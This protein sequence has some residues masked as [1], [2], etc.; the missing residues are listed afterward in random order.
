MPTGIQIRLLDV[1]A[2]KR[3][4]WPTGQSRQPVA[5]DA[6]GILRAV[7]TAEGTVQANKGK[8]TAARG[9]VSGRIGML[10]ALLFALLA[11]FRRLRGCGCGDESA[12]DADVRDRHAGRS[13]SRAGSSPSASRSASTDDFTVDR[14]QRRRQA[15]SRSSS[16]TID[17]LRRVRQAGGRRH[18]HAADLD[19]QRRQLRRTSRRTTPRLAATF[20]L[21]ALA[22]GRRQAYTSAA[23]AAPPRRRTR[24]ATSLPAT[25]TAT[26]K[27]ETRRRQPAPKNRERR[28]RPDAGVRRTRLRLN[29]PRHEPA[30]FKRRS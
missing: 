27:V 21:G 6:T 8:F 20:N 10:V 16:I 29:A 4:N 23:H 25:S 30:G 24:S 22:A 1:D 5:S 19:P 9:P 18:Q 7:L 11:D 28:D 13:L 14:A 26:R 3:P 17:G 2:N 15:T 12:D